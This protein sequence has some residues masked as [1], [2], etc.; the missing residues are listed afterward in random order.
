MFPSGIGIAAN[1]ATFAS[2][3]V[4]TNALNAEV[5][6]ALKPSTI[7]ILLYP[8]AKSL[9]FF[10]EYKTAACCRILSLAT[11]TLAVCTL[12]SS[13]FSCLLISAKAS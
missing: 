6:A 1:A 4:A 10:P 7:F 2:S 3:L 8:V 12:P 9:G 11:A 5:F 13:N